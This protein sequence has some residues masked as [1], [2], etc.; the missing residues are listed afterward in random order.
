MEK[1]HYTLKYLDCPL[2]VLIIICFLVISGCSNTTVNPEKITEQT[3]AFNKRVKWFRDAKFGVILHWGP[4]SI[5]GREISWSRDGE[6]PG[7]PSYDSTFG[8]PDV[9]VDVYDNLYKQFNPVEFDANEWVKIFQD[10]GMNYMVFVSKH[11]DGFVNF[12]S[13]Y[14]DYKI[15]SQLCPYGKDIVGMISEAC[16]KNKMRYGYY[17]SPAD[18][19]HP[20][21]HRANHSNYITYMYNQVDELCS[22][23][24]K[25]DILWF[26][27]GFPKEDWDSETL[28]EKIRIKQPNV[29]INNRLGLRGDFKTPEGNFGNLNND[30]PQEVSFQFGFSWSW[31]PNDK[32]MSWDN[33]IN[34]MIRAAGNGSNFLLGVGP[35]PN[36]KIE[37]RQVDILKQ[38]GDWL[39]IYGEGY[40]ST[41]GGPFIQ[42]N[43]GASTFRDSSVYLFIDQFTQPESL[44]LPNIGRKILK[45]T[46]FSGD[47]LEFSQTEKNITILIPDK[48]HKSP[49]T[50]IRLKLDGLINDI[51]PVKVE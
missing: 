15:T 43:W 16:N 18:W 22:N 33:T 28:V 34:Y 8:K 17:Y 30:F 20:D 9:P 21:D 12:D 44:I 11:A 26:D 6:R 32:I 13:K 4:I 38:V 24:G 14:T 47:I 36:G 35:M 49:Y 48:F 51:R 23:Y 41:Y 19:H 31:K 40:Y 45:A 50:V 3:N 46:L 25:L 10:A 37:Q 29:M 5:L 39:K 2:A 7:F 27:T 42:G 1:Q